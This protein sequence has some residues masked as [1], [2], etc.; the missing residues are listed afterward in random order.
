MIAAMSS[1]RIEKC[2]IGSPIAT[3][4]ITALNA[5]LDQRYPEEGANFFDL[6]SSDVT[7]GRGVF[8]VAFVNDVPVAATST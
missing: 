5:E 6:E 2:D 1:V 8:V 3:K 4:L 7:S